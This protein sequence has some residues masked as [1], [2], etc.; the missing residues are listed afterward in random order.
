MRLSVL[1]QTPV[2]SGSST[3]VALRN[4]IDL[5]QHADRLGYER[6][7]VAEHHGMPGLAGS[8]PE[9][10]IGHIAENTERIRV[11]SGGV[12]LSHYAPLKVAENFKV[13][14]ALH[15]GRIDVGLGRAP[16]SDHRTAQAL[17]RGGQRLSIEYYP[18][19]VQELRQLLNGT[20]PVEGPLAGITATPSTDLAPQ[21]WLLASSQ[22]S[23]A[24]AAHFGTALSWAHFISP[25][26]AEIC[27]AYREQFNPNEYRAEP[28]L[29]IGV[30]V[31]CA[32][33]EEEAEIQAATLKLWRSSGLRGPIP[34][35]AETAAAAEAEKAMPNPLAV[36]TDPR[37]QK[38]LIVGTADQVRA[39]ID[40]L[41][42]RYQA[43]EVMVVTI[44]HDHAARVR[45]YELL[46]EAYDLTS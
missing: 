35:P 23:A 12:M 41:V 9:I 1:D 36:R 25:N 15:P 22:D 31:L 14:E 24:I 29:S 6:Y 5:A 40:E 7:W 4:S 16:G 17:A 42:E 30:S 3:S 13:L 44:C 21:L 46:A 38:P 33:T 43:D 39:E 20:A 34:S 2:P 18:T 37:D 27:R 8:S 19:M 11:G 45:S 28:E 26:G 32:D 10:L